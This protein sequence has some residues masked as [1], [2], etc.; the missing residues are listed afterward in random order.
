V[1]WE[2]A[3]ELKVT[4]SVCK[5]PE[6]SVAGDSSEKTQISVGG[7]IG[8]KLTSGFVVE[9]WC[10]TSL[11]GERPYIGAIVYGAAIA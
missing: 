3:H 5:I 1:L 4:Q 6:E 10:W 2:F 9:R 11:P 8:A 7:S